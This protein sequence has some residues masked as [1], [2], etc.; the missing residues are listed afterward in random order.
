M[1]KTIRISVIMLISICT[2][3]VYGQFYTGMHMTFGK[4][5]VQY[6][7]F[8]WQY[9]RYKKYDTYF[10]VGG[11]KF[12]EF[13][14]QIAQKEITRLETYY[15]FSLNNR[16][17]FVVFNKLSDLQQ[18]NIG[19]DN[20]M[21]YNTGGVVHIVGNKVFLY[22]EGSYEKLEK[23]IRGGIARVIVNQMIYGDNLGEMVKS[24]AFTAF[25][26]WYVEGL[27]SYTQEPWNSEIENTVKDGILYGKYEKLHKLSGEEAVKAG[28]SFWKFV[29]DKYG[30]AVLP[31]II[32]MSSVTRN[33]ENGFLF[34][35]GISL[36]DLLK[37]WILHYDNI[38]YAH[39][40]LCEMPNSDN[41]LLNRNKRYAIYKEFAI[42]PDANYAVYTT[43]QLGKYKI[44]L[45]NLKKDKKKCLMRQNHKL[46]YKTDYSYPLLSWHPSGKI[47]AIIREHKGHIWLQF[48]FVEDKYFEQEELHYFDKI[49]DFNYSSDGKKMVFSAVMNGQSDIY[50]YYLGAHSYKKITNDIYDDN[51]PTYIQ[52]DK[53]I[54]FSSNR[55]NDTLKSIG[56]FTHKTYN[57]LPYND[58]FMYSFN[59]TSN[60]L[61]R[62]TNTPNTH[63]IKPVSAGN[64]E[65]FFLSNKNGIYN[66]FRA[67]FDSTI[68]FIDTITH[69]R[70]TTN[71]KPASNYKRNITEHSYALEADIFTDLVFYNDDYHLFINTEDEDILTVSKK[72]IAP[73]AI[74]VN[75][76]S[77]IQ[78]FIKKEKT[79]QQPQKK[80]RLIV[81]YE[82]D[83]AMHDTIPEQDTIIDVN[84]YRFEIEKQNNDSLHI[85]SKRQELQNSVL[86]AEKNLVAKSFNRARNYFL[87]FNPVKLV[88]Q[89]DNQMLNPTYQQ[90][91]GGGGNFFNPG[92]NGLFKLGVSDVFEDYKLTGGVKLSADLKSN[93]YFATYEDLSK[94]LDKTIL[95]HR[96]SF[97]TPY[98]E[99]FAKVYT[100]QLAYK[101][102]WPFDRVIS[103]RASLGWRNDFSV[104]KSTSMASLKEEGNYANWSYLKTELVFDNIRD[105]MM[106]IRYGT[107]GKIFGEWY[108]QIDQANT[109]FFVIGGDFRF[110]QQIHREIIWANR[111]AAS[112]SFG[113][114][115]LIY[116]LGSVD[117]WLNLSNN[118]STFNNNIDID[119]TQNYAFQTIAT[120]M[121]GFNQNIRNGNS[122]AVFNSEVRWPIFTYFSKKP[123]K[124]DFFSNFQIIGF[125]DIGTAWVGNSP[126]SEENAFYKE[127]YQNGPVTVTIIKN[128]EPIVAGY[129][130]GLRTSLFGYFIR[131]DWAWGYA[132]YKIQPQIFYLSLSLDF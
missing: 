107:R 117:N 31:N 106:N 43:N 105:V 127:E 37:D 131:A 95:F 111:I 124:S 46:D 64:S 53:R 86:K 44:W 87:T 123:I 9:Y 72:N 88:T 100:H 125:T 129:G 79:Q 49:L 60:I 97:L 122:F 110:Y 71:Y 28:H 32:Y 84:N 6:N 114:K 13:A 115:K 51:Y 42:S 18:S 77:V 24:A 48:Y 15:N 70:Y 113:N 92:L 47:L 55:P 20:D 25:P 41:D 29:V 82:Q 65:F 78:N 17:R 108:R 101:V 16:L 45:H 23:Q 5:R 59:D 120:N 102:S 22:F 132:D 34:V 81:V 61:Y 91:T 112:T 128:I 7:N 93:E 74:W 8:K 126:Y 68:S 116:Y 30:N 10:Y 80:K 33:I 89:V 11:K 54:I 90:F 99:Y 2:N 35:I 130:F 3:V 104:I 118:I 40:N 56:T 67:Q 63:E 14:S 98:N 26:D 27:I 73:K 66:R 58:L 94:R 52:N 83:T 103:F 4:N 1:K 75:N 50:E 19:L 109:N 62:V 57:P 76:D 39:D 21:D 85:N 121:R 69:Y 12:A 36:N 119:Y 96:Q 38:F